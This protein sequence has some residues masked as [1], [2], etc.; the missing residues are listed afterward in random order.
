MLLV[1]QNFTLDYDL[2]SILLIWQDTITSC[3]WLY[4]ATV[5]NNIKAQYTVKYGVTR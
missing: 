1:L 5:Y 3:I 4:A 2:Q